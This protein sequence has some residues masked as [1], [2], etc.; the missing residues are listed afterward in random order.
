L[1]NKKPQKGIEFMQRECMLGATPGDI[2]VF[3]TKTEGLNKSMIGDYIGEREDMAMKVMH[4]YVDAMDFAGM[5]YDQVGT[6]GFLGGGMVIL[7]L[8][9]CSQ[10]K[11]VGESGGAS[12]FRA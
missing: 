4:A 12:L 10:I 2:A 7:F 1:F 11:R 8:D 5:E 6:G 3:L 9:L